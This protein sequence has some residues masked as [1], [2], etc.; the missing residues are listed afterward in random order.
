LEL[1]GVP[2]GKSIA[3]FYLD[4]TKKLVSDYLTNYITRP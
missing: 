3:Q 4:E 2:M 1:V